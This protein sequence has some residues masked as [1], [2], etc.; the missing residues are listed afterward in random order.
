M[1]EVGSKMFAAR[2]DR[3]RSFDEPNGES[4]DKRSRNH[5]DEPVPTLPGQS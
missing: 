4:R 2:L 3:S 5:R 1:L